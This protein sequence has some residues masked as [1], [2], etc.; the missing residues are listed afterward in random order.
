M[1]Q[2]SLTE[3]LEIWES[4]L[5]TYKRPILKGLYVSDSGGGG[6]GGGGKMDKCCLW[7]SSEPRFKKGHTQKATSPL[8]CSWFMGFCLERLPGVHLFAGVCKE[9]VACFN[10]NPETKKCDLRRQ[11]GPICEGDLLYGLTA[12][13]NRPRKLLNLYCDQRSV[14]CRRWLV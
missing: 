3:A 6:G 4:V 13:T 14:H 7:L 8:H 2:Q 9:Q 1:Q 10:Q 11:E 12:K 5:K